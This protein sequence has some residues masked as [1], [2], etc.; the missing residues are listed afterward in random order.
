MKHL[1]LAIAAA[2]L[3]AGCSYAVTLDNVPVEVNSGTPLSQA[4]AV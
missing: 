3:M 2:V 1:L 4:G